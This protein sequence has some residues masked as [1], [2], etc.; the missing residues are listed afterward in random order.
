MTSAAPLAIGLRMTSAIDAPSEDKAAGFFG[1]R[2]GKALRDEQ[3]GRMASLLPQLKVDVSGPI[4][5]PTL[6]GGAME[7]YRLEIGF[8]GGEHLADIAEKHPGIGFLGCEPFVNGVAKLLAE[9]EA[10]GLANIRIHDGNA[11]DVLSRLPGASLAG[12]DLLYPD[13]WPKRRQRKRRFVSDKSLKALANV[14]QPGG[15]FRFASDIDD[16]CGWVLQR[17]ARSPDFTWNAE[18][19]GD[20]IVPYAG[21][22]G[23]RYEA[24]AKREGRVPSYLRFERN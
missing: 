18:H 2:K 15:T 5:L 1:R 3:A 14:L 4:D 11:S 9:I 7:A 8:G 24:K 20:W 23:T 10:R 22:P 17:I 16:Y 6:F 21:W 12:I 19:A 13:P